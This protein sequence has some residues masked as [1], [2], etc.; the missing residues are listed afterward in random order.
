[1]TVLYTTGPIQNTNLYLANI[2]VIVRNTDP[3]DSATITTRLFDESS[4]PESLVKSN[5]FTVNAKSTNS[6]LYNA[7]ALTSFLIEVEVNLA[8]KSD[9]VASTAVQSTVT[10]FNGVSEFVQFIR[11]L[12]S[13]PQTLQNIE[14]PITPQFNLFL[15]STISCEG[16]NNG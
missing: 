16:E 11:L 12:V 7:A 5:S 15:P 9:K 6:E 13:N 4:S 3:S 8:N 1:M 10:A 14:Y 2:E